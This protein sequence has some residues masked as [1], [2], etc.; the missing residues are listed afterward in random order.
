MAKATELNTPI[1]SRRAL[2]AGAPAAAT[3]AL[4]AGTAVN[5][6]AI[7]LATA[8]E[9]DPIFE[10]IA[11]HTEACAEVRRWSD[12]YGEL[13]SEDPEH[14]KIEA[15]EKA[16]LHREEEA[17][18]ALLSCPPTTL[19]GVIAVLEHVGKGEFFFGESNEA[20]LTGAHESAAEEANA[21]PEH[22]AAALRNIVERGQA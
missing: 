21:F 4:L 12:I 11:K 15:Q 3:G 10:L 20:I 18:A 14:D 16:A 1:S 7:G 13:S 5:A 9:V 6:V 19:A 2:L 17:I 8:A 22:L